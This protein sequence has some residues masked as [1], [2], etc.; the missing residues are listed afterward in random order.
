[1]SNASLTMKVHLFLPTGCD[2]FSIKNVWTTLT[3]SVLLLS[4][5]GLIKHVPIKNLQHEY[6]EPEHVLCAAPSCVISYTY[7]QWIHIAFVF[8]TIKPG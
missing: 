3:G 7:L 5:Q 2:S 1:M 4:A 6:M 8:R